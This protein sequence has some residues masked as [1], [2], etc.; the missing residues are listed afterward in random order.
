M[1]LAIWLLALAASGLLAVSTIVYAV[2]CVFGS[3]PRRTAPETTER[4]RAAVAVLVPAHDE[5]HGIAATLQNIAAQL[6]DGDRLLVVA[7]NCSDRTAKVAGATGAEVVERHDPTR[8]GKGY[9]L[10]YGLAHLARD[11]R[12]VVIVVDADCTLLTGAIDE[13]S[14]TVTAT[15]RP[16]QSCYLM[17]AS[18]EQKRRFG[19][20]EFAFLV[21]NLVRPRG[22][23]RLGLPCQLTGAGMAIPWAAIGSID[24]AHGHLVEDMKLGLDLAASGYAPVYCEDADVRSAFPETAVGAE[25]QRRRWEYGHLAMLAASGRRLLNRQVLGDPKRLAMT[26]DIL[27]PPLTLLAAGIAAV[28]AAGAVVAGLG[29]GLAPLAVSAGSGLLLL[30]ATAAAWAVHGRQ[31]LPARAVLGIPGYMLGK[32]RMYPRA[33]VGKTE[34]VWVRTDRTRT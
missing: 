12:P 9:A 33:L 26:L 10:D 19:V 21:K 32:V 1:E 15:G 5:E 6:R 27:V 28:I 22:L 13:L 7:D 24:L 23:A 20:A 25:S 16:A 17:V 11:P 34:Q 30:L 14:R 2:E 4:V 18:V 3:L 8:R 29:F 31:V